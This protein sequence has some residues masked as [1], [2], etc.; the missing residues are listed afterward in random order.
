[1]ADMADKKKP[2]AGGD[3]EDRG[4]GREVEV[5][6]FLLGGHQHTLTLPANSE[7]LH[8]LFSALAAS[9]Q[10]HPRP[11]A[12]FFQ[13]PAD[14]G[15]SVCSFSSSQLVSIITAPPVLIED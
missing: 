11:L 3:R 4:D 14:G 5:Q 13:I 9:T 10:P 8:D 12:R 15:H 7:I 2:S 6:L 1:M